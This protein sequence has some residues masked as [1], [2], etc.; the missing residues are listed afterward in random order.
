MIKTKGI[1]ETLPLKP[2]DLMPW[3]AGMSKTNPSTNQLSP[4]A[5]E[6]IG[7]LKRSN[8]ADLALIENRQINEQ[9]QE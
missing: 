6:I 4:L 7:A 3:S 8:E 5:Q 1:P 2:E 9:D